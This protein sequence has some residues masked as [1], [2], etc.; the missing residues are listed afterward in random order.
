[1]KFL[2]FIASIGFIGFVGLFE[3]IG[4]AG[5]LELKKNTT[6]PTNPRNSINKN[7]H[8]ECLKKRF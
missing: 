4:F 5:L 1:M 3:F 7:L 8:T 6:D 2:G